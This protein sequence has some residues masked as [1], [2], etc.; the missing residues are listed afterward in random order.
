MAAFL[1]PHLMIPQY[2]YIGIVALN[3]LLGAHLHGKE[4]KEKTYNFWMTLVASILAV[5]LLTWGGFFD[6]L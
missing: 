5:S 1:N 3:L 6:G 2:I 4:R